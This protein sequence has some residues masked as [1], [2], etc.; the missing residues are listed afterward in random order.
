MGVNDIPPGMLSAPA[1][2]VDITLEVRTADGTCYTTATRVGFST[3][4]RRARVATPGTQLSVYIDPSDRSRV[5]IDTSG[6]F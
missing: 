4:E 3:P 6:L 2:M 1:G 5:A